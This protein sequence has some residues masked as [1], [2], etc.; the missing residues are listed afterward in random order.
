MKSLEVQDDLGRTIFVDRITLALVLSLLE[1][2][3][4]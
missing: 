1:W 2:K 4:K 3:R